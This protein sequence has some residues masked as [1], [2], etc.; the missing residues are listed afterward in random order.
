[1]NNACPDGW[2][3]VEDKL[4]VDPAANQ[5]LLVNKSFPNLGPAV[6]ILR[7]IALGAK[8]I[9]SDTCGPF[10][11]AVMLKA[12]D[13]GINL[14]GRTIVATYSLYQVM[15]VLPKAEDIVKATKDL[16]KELK[17]NGIAIPEVIKARLQELEVPA[18]HEEKPAEDEA[19]TGPL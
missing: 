5:M 7:P 16:R 10:F 6:D 17:E 13:A 18:P 11:S 14:G 9:T 19:T 1:M 4:I 8:R 2:Q 15:V 12:L 3:A